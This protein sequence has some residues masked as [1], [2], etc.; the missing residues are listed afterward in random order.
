MAKKKY[1]VWTS[2]WFDGKKLKARNM[3]RKLYGSNR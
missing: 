2:T 1:K 3:Q